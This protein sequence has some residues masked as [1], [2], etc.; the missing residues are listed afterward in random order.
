M[1]VE[2][3][4]LIIVD[5][6]ND[7]IHDDGFSGT[8]A[9]GGVNMKDRLKLLR[10]PVPNIKRLAEHFRRNKKEVVHIYTACER[11]YSDV[12]MP[13]KTI[14]KAK[15]AGALVEGT[16]GAKIVDELSPHG[17]DHVVRK[18]G[19]G[20]F[21]HTPLDRTLRNMDIKTLIMTGVNTSYCVET[22]VREG[23]AYGYDIVLVKD[24][25]AC[26]DP[27]SHEASLKVIAGGF[28]EVMTT[29]EVLALLK[30]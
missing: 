24:A 21:F 2:R 5:M 30:W 11:D 25:T 27:E 12:A 9:E 14:A 22:T 23:V 4:A 20:G 28:G 26:F 17:C 3:V 19:S 1:D 8:Y 6:Q 15:E 13:L 29:E 7:F 18:T 16:W 10:A